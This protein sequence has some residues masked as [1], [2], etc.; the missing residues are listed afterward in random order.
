MVLEEFLCGKRGA[1]IRIMR[2]DGSENCGLVGLRERAITGSPSLFRAKRT[3]A[4]LLEGL[5]QSLNLP[6]AYSQLSRGTFRGHDSIPQLGKNLQFLELAFV[7]VDQHLT[8]SANNPRSSHKATSLM[9]ESATNLMG[10]Y[11]FLAHNKYTSPFSG[12]LNW[13]QVFRRS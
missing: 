7:H 8:G 2:P 10:A 13:T 3:G 11:I 6:S 12:F 5:G 9:S 1:K 4:I